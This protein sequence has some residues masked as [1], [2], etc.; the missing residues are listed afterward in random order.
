MK[1]SIPTMSRSGCGRSIT[2]E[3]SRSKA[4]ILTALEAVGYPAAKQTI[5][6]GART[7]RVSIRAADIP[8]A[9]TR[10]GN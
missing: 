5:R 9:A 4:A 7:G 8:H 6:G 10:A 2:V 1:L 3:P